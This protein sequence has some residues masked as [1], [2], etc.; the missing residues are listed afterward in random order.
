MSEERRLAYVAIT[1]AK[2]RLYIT[3]AKNR[4]MYGRT[5]F[6]MLS[7]FVREEIPESLI[8]RAWL[9]KAPP[10][11]PLS[12]NPST[13]RR[14]SEPVSLEFSRRPEIAPAP[15]KSGA[16]EY[17]IEKFSVGA[18]VGHSMFGE[19]TV[20]SSRDMGGDVL[21]E[22]KFDTGVVKKLMATYAQ[23]RKL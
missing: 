6:G 1:R 7:C 14:Y 19:G 10:R 17:G 20:I 5:N 4:T 3:Y 23:L 21:Y 11:A 12:Y 9:R 13:R 22:V 2:E 8:D 18:R 15:R 16:S